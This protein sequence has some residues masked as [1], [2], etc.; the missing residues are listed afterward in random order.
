MPP[1]KESKDDLSLSEARRIALAAQGFDRL[2]PTSASRPVTTQHLRR[3]IRQLGL[4]QI[5]Y[6]NVLVPAHYQ[7]LDALA[8]ELRTMAAWLDLDSVAVGR[9]VGFARLLAA[10]ACPEPLGPLPR[11]R[12]K[13][14]RR[15]R[16]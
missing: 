1:R 6:V 16:A 5:D 11:A 14:R 3:T 15:G 2:R 8:A 4:L 9:R 12:G 13:L 10:A 7:V